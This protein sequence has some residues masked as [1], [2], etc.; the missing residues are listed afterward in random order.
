LASDRFAYAVAIDAGAWTALDNYVLVPPGG[1]T[2]VR[3]SGGPGRAPSSIEATALN[4]GRCRIAL[5]A[6]A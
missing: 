1:T 6:Q 2:R 4:G 3:L 5:G